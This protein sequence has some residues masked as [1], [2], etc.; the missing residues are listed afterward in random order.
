MNVDIEFLPEDKL[1]DARGIIL[2]RVKCEDATPSNLHRLQF[3]MQ[4]VL[5]GRAA[6][7]RAHVFV[8]PHGMSLRTVPEREMNR[9]GWYRRKTKR[10]AA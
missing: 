6:N 9:A 3:L 2:I 8:V 10:A 5:K 7:E 4:D 1:R